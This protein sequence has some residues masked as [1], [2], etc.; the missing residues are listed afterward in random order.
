PRWSAASMMRAPTA[1]SS[2]SARPIGIDRGETCHDRNPRTQRHPVHQRAACQSVGRNG[3][4]AVRMVLPRPLARRDRHQDRRA[5][6]RCETTFYGPDGEVVPQKGI[7]LAFDEGRR[8]VTT[9]AAVLGE[10]GDLEPTG[11]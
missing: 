3:Q 8:F 6:G 5:G 1:P 10:D 9:D 7:Y 11:P 4:P 2:R